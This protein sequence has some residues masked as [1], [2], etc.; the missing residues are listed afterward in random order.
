MTE[1]PGRPRR[2]VMCVGLLLLVATVFGGRLDGVE[3]CQVCRARAETT[4]WGLTLGDSIGVPVYGTRSET[5]TERSGATR[6]AE[7]GPEAV[8]ARAATSPASA[9]PPSA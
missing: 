5:P 8:H 1:V 4:T 9:I 3:V 6:I 2:R 7:F